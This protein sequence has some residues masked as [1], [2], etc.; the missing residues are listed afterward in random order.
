MKYLLIQRASESERER[1]LN[2]R[3]GG[4]YILS[5]PSQHIIDIYMYA[6][7]CLLDD[8]FLFRLQNLNDY[9]TISAYA[10][11]HQDQWIFLMNLNTRMKKISY[12]F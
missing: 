1:N 4:K 3:G 11:M 9:F 8:P 6:F 2:E 7:R 10:V 5:G 12:I